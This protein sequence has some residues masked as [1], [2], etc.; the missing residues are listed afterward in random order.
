M[1]PIMIIQ[2]VLA[3]LLVIFVLIQ[4]RG[5]GLGSSWGGS[6]EFYVTRRGFE[7]LLFRA[8]ITTAIL[9]VTFSFLGL[10]S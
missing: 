7:K 9:F 5:A 8:T 3:I 2:V 1:S 4:N 6:G 10:I